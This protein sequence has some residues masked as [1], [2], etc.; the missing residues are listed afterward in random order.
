MGQ[1]QQVYAARRRQATERHEDHIWC[2]TRSVPWE[3]W[4]ERVTLPSG[5][6]PIRTS[7]RCMLYV[8]YFKTRNTKKLNTCS[9]AIFDSVCCLC[10]SWCWQR[11]L[12]RQG[13]VSGLL[14]AG[15]LW[16]VYRQTLL[17][18]GCLH[19]PK[20]SGQG[21]HCEWMVTRLFPSVCSCKSLVH[22]Y[23]V[24]AYWWGD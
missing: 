2:Q 16:L 8:Q 1:Q 4:V 9:Y 15:T 13:A 23:A 10:R 18:Q 21:D 22:H 14:D 12:R 6:L 17:G 11:P 3:R 5:K 19:A 7:V 20:Q 24:G